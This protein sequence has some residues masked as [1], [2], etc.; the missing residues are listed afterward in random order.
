MERNVSRFLQFCMRGRQR[1]K[2][3][4]KVLLRRSHAA[5]HTFL[6]RS[7]TLTGGDKHIWGIGRNCKIGLRMIVAWPEKI[8]APCNCAP[9]PPFV[10]KSVHQ[11]VAGEKPHLKIMICET[12]VPSNIILQ[13]Y[14]SLFKFH[15]W[16]WED[17]MSLLCNLFGTFWDEKMQ[18]TYISL[19]SPPMHISPTWYIHVPVLKGK[20]PSKADLSLKSSRTYDCSQV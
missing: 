14:L 13:I 10:P 1:E 3:E 12:L 2:R 19:L 11:H 15:S 4:G 5:F 20:A 18:L 7:E 8:F 9:S 16:K 17:T 6:P